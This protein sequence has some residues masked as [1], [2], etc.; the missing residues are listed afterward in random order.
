MSD[1]SI[2][3]LAI[4]RHIRYFGIV[5]ISSPRYARWKVGTNRFHA[6]ASEASLYELS[7]YEYPLINRRS[8]ILDYVL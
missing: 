7:I 8:C 6:R 4:P 5:A 2:N 1:I 3:R